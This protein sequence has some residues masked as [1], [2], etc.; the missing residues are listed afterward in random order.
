MNTSGPARVPISGLRSEIRL[1]MSAPQQIDFSIAVPPRYQDLGPATYSLGGNTIY[2]PNQ[3]N[4]WSGYTAQGSLNFRFG[5][6]DYPIK[7]R[8]FHQLIENGFIGTSG[9][10]L[11]LNETSAMSVQVSG[12]ETGGRTQVRYRYDEFTSA[13]TEY[14]P[15][16]TGD[17]TFYWSASFSCQYY[18]E[19]N[20]DFSRIN[21]RKSLTGSN[22]DTSID[23][24]VQ[25][26]SFDKGYSLEYPGFFSQGPA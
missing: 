4:Q 16:G 26:F 5:S 19:D 13:W 22:I 1:Y 21:I 24:G 20:L 17:H 11:F 15:I 12:Y 23:A 10:R 3:Y 7:K 18:D 2:G 8:G 25:S 6:F 14:D 9:N